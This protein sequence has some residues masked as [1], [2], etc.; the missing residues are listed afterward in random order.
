MRLVP[1]DQ[2]DRKEAQQA[3]HQRDVVLPGRWA[4]QKPEDG[5]SER[6]SKEALFPPA[7][8]EDRLGVF[9]LQLV[10]IV[11]SRRSINEYHRKVDHQVV[12]RL[13]LVLELDLDGGEYT[14]YK[15]GTLAGKVA[16]APLCFL[17]ESKRPESKYR[18]DVNRQLHN[19]FDGRDE[20]C[21]SSDEG[22]MY[23]ASKPHRTRVQNN[24]GGEGE[25]DRDQSGLQKTRWTGNL[26]FGL[27]AHMRA[28]QYGQSSNG[29]GDTHYS[30]Q[31]GLR[32]AGRGDR[33]T[34]LRWPIVQI[35]RDSIRRRA[36][37][38]G[39]P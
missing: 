36:L 10:L 4:W 39:C 32:Y 28:S 12:E 1:V 34:R 31:S 38:L 30:R 20:P 37:Q 35:P 19:S 26:C 27:P 7:H 23:E 25:G 2:E 24:E 3:H 13:I 22:G 5:S 21:A 14:L 18:S 29:R 8:R 33:G 11:D 15:C 9:D 17:G 6:G 16:G